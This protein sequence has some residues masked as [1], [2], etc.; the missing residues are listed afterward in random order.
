MK[1]FDSG[2]A[3][4]FEEV[5]KARA[6]L[7]S[8][9]GKLREVSGT[10][11]SK[12]RAVTASVDASG[13]LTE[14]KFNSTDYR[15]MAPKELSNLLLEVIGK[16]RQDARSKISAAT[17]SFTGPA[18]TSMQDLLSGK[19]DISKI[20]PSTLPTSPAD[21]LKFLRGQWE[22]EDKAK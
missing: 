18:A 12:N 10:A 5:A 21:M 16:A 6:E 11:T 2:L 7:E 8:V 22:P 15:A 17:G 14:L 4:V 3:E 19:T 20:L 13:E 1:P 9:T